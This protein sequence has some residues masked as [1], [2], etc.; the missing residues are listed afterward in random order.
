MCELPLAICVEGERRSSYTTLVRTCA[1]G[2]VLDTS[3]VGPERAHLNSDYVGDPDRTARSSHFWDA[4]DH[5]PVYAGW[6][7][8]EHPR[9]E[10]DVRWAPRKCL[11]DHLQRLL[12]LLEHL[13]Y[14]AAIDVGEDA[15]RP[16]EALAMGMSV[17][18]VEVRPEPLRSGLV[19]VLGSWG[20]LRTPG[21][22]H[23]Q[24]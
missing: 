8:V 19:S 23:A 14:G 16:F 13:G 12:D 21:E 17:E 24:A 4:P 5:A 10:I 15:L 7:S 20:P 22:R 1:Y 2:V 18:S 9:G 11:Y 6:R 3:V